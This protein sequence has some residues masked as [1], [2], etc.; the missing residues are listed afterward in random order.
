MTFKPRKNEFTLGRFLNNVLRDNKP[1]K[2]KENKKK[3][4]KKSNEKN[5]SN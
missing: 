1:S 2:E 4:E 5:N 3:E